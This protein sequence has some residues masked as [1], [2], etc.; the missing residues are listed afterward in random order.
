MDLRH[1]VEADGLGHA[2]ALLDLVRAGDRGV[3]G[4]D[5]YGHPRLEE[6][7]DGMARARPHRP[8][9]VV[10][11]HAALHDDAVAGQAAQEIRVLRRRAPVPDARGPQLVHRL[12]DVLRRRVLARVRGHAQPAQ[13]RD[14]VGALEEPR[15][16]PALG[17]GDVEP[18]DTRADVKVL[19]LGDG[20][21]GQDLGDVRPVLAHGDHH[22]AELHGMA[23]A[24]AVHAREDGAD[25]LPRREAGEGVDDRRVAQLEGLDPCRGRL[26]HDGLRHLADVLVEL[27]DPERVVHLV[28]VGEQRPLLLRLQLQAAAHLVL[29]FRG[30]QAVVAHEL[31]RDVERDGAVDVLVELDLGEGPDAVFEVGHARL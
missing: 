18:H 25:G 6:G 10:A 26:V 14:L 24:R 5:G 23:P 2:R 16:V 11:G 30:V 21:P 9:V 15:R 22:Q 8:R 19:G 31:P 4:A 12:P 27:R 28:Q 29:G 1:R 13:P 20:L 7:V 3:V 17:A